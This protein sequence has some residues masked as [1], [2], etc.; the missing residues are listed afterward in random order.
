M[1][2]THILIKQSILR[3]TF[4]LGANFCCLFFPT[5]STIFNCSLEKHLHSNNSSTFTWF[6][7]IREGEKEYLLARWLRHNS[8]NNSNNNNRSSSNA[9]GTR[10]RVRMTTRAAVGCWSSRKMKEWLLGSPLMLNTPLHVTQT[11]FCSRDPSQAT[12]GT[13]SI[14]TARI[15]SWEITTH[16]SLIHSKF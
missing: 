4:Y 11:T 16:W 10:K 9:K 13:D 15:I 12:A 5:L 6:S 3:L 8:R 2:V 1:C 7:G 14:R